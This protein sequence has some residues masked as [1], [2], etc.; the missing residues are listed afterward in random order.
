MNQKKSFEQVSKNETLCHQS[1][2][3]SGINNLDSFKIRKE[4]EKPT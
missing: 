1:L 3:F 2:L 4:T